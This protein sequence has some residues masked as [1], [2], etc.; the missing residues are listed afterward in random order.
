MNNKV[1]LKEYIHP[2][3]EI[4]FLALNA[5]DVSNENEH[6]FSRNLSFWNLLYDA[7]LITDRI[8]NPLS[9]DEIVF[10]NIRINY[11]SWAYG[12]TDLNRKVVQ[13]NSSIVETNK[14]QVNRILEILNNHEVKKLCIMHSAVSAEFEK[15]GVIKRGIGTERDGYGIVGNYNNT[16]II[17]VPF[18]NASIVDK[19]I[20][21]R[22]LKL[23]VDKSKKFTE[24]IQEIIE[25]RHSSIEK[26]Y[27]II[28]DVYQEKYDWSLLDP[29]RHEICICIMFGLCQA[30][31]TLTNHLL[32]SLLKNALII[33]HAKNIKQTKGEIKG[34]IITSLEEK[35]KE[36]IKLYDNKNL[37]HNINRAFTVGLIT[38][39]QKKD[40]HDFRNRFRNAY[41]HASKNKTFEGATV[42]VTGINLNEGR[43][44]TD[45]SKNVNIAGFLVGQGIFQWKISQELGPQYFLYIDSLV[46]QIKNKIFPI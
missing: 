25:S 3:M 19:H 6:W 46:R 38:K 40:L 26:H 23:D 7:G 31:I 24:E 28:R 34:R 12:V 43:I 45:E 27:I 13:T 17:E 30:G 41:S 4:L 42:P 5:P 16:I 18:H 15:A 11:K 32:E 39:E 21:Y 14:A 33:K 9:G 29:L 20:I 1:K 35:Y 22:C 37:N 2:K 36:A 10:N 8:N 44:E